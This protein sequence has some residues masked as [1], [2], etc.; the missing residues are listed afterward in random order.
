MI[1]KTNILS[2]VVENQSGVLSRIVG[3]FSGKGYNIESIN[4]AITDD[5]SISRVT[6]VTKANKPV[7]EQIKKQLNKLIYVIKVIDLTDT[8]CVQREMHLIKVHART[9]NRAEILRI[10]DIFR[11]KVVD[12]GHQH[13]TLEVTGDKGKLN[14]L[15][16][17]LRPI[18]LKEVVKT[19]I[20]ALSRENSNSSAK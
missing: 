14:A 19:G 15:I 7:V 11:C 10:V 2:I 16:N 4:A 6:I 18:G 13:Y 12:V 20:I 9:E 8:N 1:E 17:L 3:L 5:P